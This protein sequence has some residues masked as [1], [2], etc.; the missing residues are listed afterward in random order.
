MVLVRI[1]KKGGK[2]GKDPRS[3]EFR[4]RKALYMAYVAF[5]RRIWE[6]ERV[7]VPVDSEDKL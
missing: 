7:A 4:L 6:D 3:S 2:Y 5:P 1:E